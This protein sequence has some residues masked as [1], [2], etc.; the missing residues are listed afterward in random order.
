MKSKSVT[1]Y[2]DV[3]EMLYNPS[4]SNKCYM[5]RTTNYSGEKYTM[6]LNKEDL[7]KLANLINNF[8]DQK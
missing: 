6:T 3:V 4:V 8:L 1:L 5:I 2:D 7:G